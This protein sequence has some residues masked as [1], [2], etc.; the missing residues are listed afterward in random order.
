VSLD[1][2]YIDGAKIESKANKYNIDYFF[3]PKWEINDKIESE[4]L[5]P[6][7]KELTLFS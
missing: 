4:C 6:S 3:P 7:L 2:E 1:V 5:Q